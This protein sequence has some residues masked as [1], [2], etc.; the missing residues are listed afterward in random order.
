MGSCPS[1]GGMSVF[2]KNLPKPYK[3]RRE[4]S[5]L[6]KIPNFYHFFFHTEFCPSHGSKSDDEHQ[7]LLSNPNPV[8]LNQVSLPTRWSLQWNFDQNGIQRAASTSL[9]LRGFFIWLWIK[10]N[11]LNAALIKDGRYLSL[12]LWPFH[13]KNYWECPMQIKF[14]WNFA[15]ARENGLCRLMLKPQIYRDAVK[16]RPNWG[17]QRKDQCVW[18]HNAVIQPCSCSQ[19]TTFLFRTLLAKYSNIWPGVSS[20]HRPQVTFQISAYCQI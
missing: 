15:I 20:I 2:I 5:R 16:Q 13:C 8:L 9:V 11:S 14:V 6:G 4:L 19:T 12:Q 3:G 18:S 17:F 7:G 1:K 10:L